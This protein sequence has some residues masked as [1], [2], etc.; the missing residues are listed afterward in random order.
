[1]APRAPWPAGGGILSF[2]A[3]QRE[4]LR[5][6]WERMLRHP[7]LLRTRDGTLPG[8]TFATW[9]RQD[10]LFVEAALPF[11]A[12]LLSRAPARGWEM[13]V[14]A[15][16]ALLAELRLFE[17]RAAALGVELEGTRPS[18]TCHAYV[19]FLLATAATRSYAEAYTV[20][21][22]AEKAYH[23]SWSVVREG[24]EESSPWFPFV[25]KWAGEPFAVFVAQLEAELD[26]L[27]R[28]AG[29]AEQSRMAELFEITVRYEIAFWEMALRGEAWPGLEEPASG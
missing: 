5:P 26:R 15:L 17:E 4:R 18:L 22:V 11:V 12:A 23:D 9:L 2:C 1:M 7:F 29:E 3:A 19:Q 16:N 28:E 20:Y 10:Y 8:E 14:G 6:L 24:L 27:A 13:L 21:Y 25:E